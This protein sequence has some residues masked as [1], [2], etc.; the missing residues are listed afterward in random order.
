VRFSDVSTAS[1]KLQEE[2]DVALNNLENKVKTALAASF[3]DVTCDSQ[4]GGRL[5]VNSV[6]PRK[7]AKDK[8]RFVFC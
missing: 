3:P 2:Q 8:L 4:V 5:V 1:F 7:L 6:D